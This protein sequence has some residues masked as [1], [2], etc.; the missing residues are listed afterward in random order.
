M[1]VSKAVELQKG[2]PQLTA[3]LSVYADQVAQM[4]LSPFVSKIVFANSAG[5]GEPPSP[6][7][8]IA[9]PTPVLISLANAILQA[10]KDKH[11]VAQINK[12]VDQFKADL[13]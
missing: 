6:V 10:M 12:A 9:I 2:A 4:N 3:P 8:S 5:Q 7:L 1:S 11:T 13:N